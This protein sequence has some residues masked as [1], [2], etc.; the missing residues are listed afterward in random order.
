MTPPFDQRLARALVRP[1]AGTALH[2]NHLTTLGLVL[3]LAGAGVMAQ[4]G[5]LVHLGAA[6]FMLAC[7][8]DHADGEL[9][10]LSGKSSR[11]GHYYDR[12][13]ALLTYVA[14]FVGAGAGL[15]DDT[16]MGSAAPAC[17]VVAG[18]S[19]AG[20][21]GARLWLEARAG[22]AAVRQDSLVGFEP[23]DALY[24]VGPITW[25]GWLE[26][27][28]LAAAFGAPAFLILVIWQGLR[29]RSA[30]AWRSPQSAERRK[31]PAVPHGRPPPTK[32]TGEDPG[33]RS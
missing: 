30:T 22:P 28:V 17:G 32:A 23:E 13:T 15:P 25:L 18:L 33:P 12:A 7:L 4:G 26:H 1:F 9:A 5:A 24:L 27:F 11:F 8:M 6:L 21:F 3:G 16:L 31:R 2:P 14:M 20:I 29:G 10:R 19:V